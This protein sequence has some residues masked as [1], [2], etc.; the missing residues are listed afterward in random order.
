M[1]FYSQISRDETGAPKKWKMSSTLPIDEDSIKSKKGGT[2]KSSLAGSNKGTPSSSRENSNERKSRINLSLQKAGRKNSLTRDGSSSEQSSSRE[3]S[4]ENKVKGDEKKLKKTDLDKKNRSFSSDSSKVRKSLGSDSTLNSD[5][6]KKKRGRPKSLDLSSKEMA[7]GDDDHFKSPD[8]LTPCN[9]GFKRKKGR[10]KETPPVLYAEPPVETS[11]LENMT[12]YETEDSSPP[13]KRKPGRPKKVKMF[14]RDQLKSI[15]KSDNLKAFNIKRQYGS[16]IGKSSLQQGFRRAKKL[17]KLKPVMTPIQINKTD[18]SSMSAVETEG[19]EFETND[20]S[21][22]NENGISPNEKR[23]PGRPLGAKNKQIYGALTALKN[24][25]K[26]AKAIV[27]RKITQ[28][29][30][31][32]LKKAISRG[33]G[34]PPGTKNKSTPGKLSG[35][36]NTDKVETISNSSKE[37]SVVTEKDEVPDSFFENETEGDM[38]VSTVDEAIETVLFKARHDISIELKNRPKLSFRPQGFFKKLTSV[39]SVAKFKKE[40]DIIRKI[41]KKRIL[42]THATGE[43]F[44]QNVKPLASNDLRRKLQSRLIEKM[45]FEHNIKPTEGKGAMQAEDNVQKSENSL[46]ETNL[47]PSEDSKT[48]L[49]SEDSAKSVEVNG[50][51]QTATL[52]E[53]TIIKPDSENIADT[54]NVRKQNF[55]F[56]KFSDTE[57]V[58]SELSTNSIGSLKRNIEKQVLILGEENT[59]SDDQ[60]VRTRQRFEII[61]G[62][63]RKRTLSGEFDLLDEKQL[64]KERKK[65]ERIQTDDECDLNQLQRETIIPKKKPLFKRKKSPIKKSPTLKVKDGKIVKKYVSQ[66]TAYRNRMLKQSPFLSRVRKKRRK[67]YIKRNQENSEKTLAAQASVDSTNQSGKFNSESMENASFVADSP[68][69]KS[70]YYRQGLFEK[71]TDVTLENKGESVEDIQVKD[72][73]NSNNVN[74]GEDG[75]SDDTECTIELKDDILPE[76]PP[77]EESVDDSD[78]IDFHAEMKLESTGRELYTESE[79][80][81]REMLFELIDDIVEDLEKKRGSFNPS[82]DEKCIN[83]KVETSK[84]KENVGEHVGSEINE[85]NCVKEDIKDCQNEGGDMKEK[86]Q[87]VN[88]SNCEEPN[89]MI[90]SERILGTKDEKESS[91]VKQTIT[92]KNEDN[93]KLVSE[94][95]NVV[96]KEINEDINSSNVDTAIEGEAKQIKKV[97]IKHKMKR[98]RYIPL[99][100]RK[101]VDNVTDNKIR[102]KPGRKPKPKPDSNITSNNETISETVIEKKSNPVESKSPETSVIRK[103]ELRQKISRSPLDNIALKQSLEENEYLR[104]EAQKLSRKEAKFKLK[105]KIPGQDSLESSPVQNKDQESTENTVP[106]IPELTEESDTEIEERAESVEDLLKRC[107]PCKIVLKDFIKELERAQVQAES[108]CESETELQDIPNISDEEKSNSSIMQNDTENKIE[109]ASQGETQLTNAIESGLEDTDKIDKIGTEAGH[110][111]NVNLS[112]STSNENVNEACASQE[113]AVNDD[114]NNVKLDTPCEQEKI[115][116]QSNMHDVKKNEIENSSPNTKQRALRPKR[117]TPVK[118]QELSSIQVAITPPKKVRK[119]KSINEQQ[120]ARKTVPPLKIKV[121]GGF[122]SRRK[123]YIVEPSPDSPVELSSKEEQKAEKKKEKSKTKSGNKSESSDSEKHNKNH[124]HHHRKKTKTPTDDINIEQSKSMTSQ[125]KDIPVGQSAVY[126]E[127]PPLKAT[128]AYEANFLQFIQDKDKVEQNMAAFSNSLGSKSKPSNQSLLKT[129]QKDNT[130]LNLAMAKTSPTSS[131]IEPSNAQIQSDTQNNIENTEVQYVCSQC[132]NVVYKTKEQIAQHYREVHPGSQFIYKPLPEATENMATIENPGNMENNSLH[133]SAG[134]NEQPNDDDDSGSLNLKIVDVV[135]LKDQE[136]LID[137]NTVI[138][139]EEQVAPVHSVPTSQIQT[140]LRIPSY[141][142]IV[143]APPPYPVHSNVLP[144]PYSVATAGSA[145]QGHVISALQEQLQLKSKLAAPKQKSQVAGKIGNSFKCEKCNVHAPMLAAMV[146]H[147]RNSHKEIPR[148]FQC[149]YCKDMEAETEALIHQHIKKLHPTNNP[150]PPV[151]LSEPAK[152]NLKT[153]SVRLPEGIKLGEGNSIEKDI[154]MCLKCKEHMPSLET[155]YEHLEHEHSE[156]FA[157][158][159]PVCKVFKSKTEHLVN[160]HIKVVHNRKSSEVN[161]SLAIDGN[162]FVRIQCLVKDKTKSGQR[163][164]HSAQ[165]KQQPS[166]VP[167]TVQQ[168]KP[169]LHVPGLTTAHLQLQPIPQVSIPQE[170]ST[171]VSSMPLNPL[172][173]PNLNFSAPP[174]GTKPVQAPLVPKKKKSLLESIQKIKVQKMEQQGLLSQKGQSTSISSTIPSHP[175]QLI[176]SKP[177]VS[178]A[179]VPPPLMRAPPPLIRYDQLNKV[180]SPQSIM[181]GSALQ[182]QA[183]LTNLQRLQNITSSQTVLSSSGTPRSIQSSLFD[184]SDLDTLKTPQSQRPVLNVPV[185]SRPSSKGPFQKVPSASSTPDNTETT[186]TGSPLDLSKTT[187]SASPVPQGLQIPNMGPVQVSGAS[188]NPD[189]FQ[190]F[191][192]RPSTQMQL[193]RPQIPVPQMLTQPIMIPQQVRQNTP[194]TLAYRP[195]GSQ[196]IATSQVQQLIG[197]PIGTAAVIGNMVVSLGNMTQ[198][199]PAMPVGNQALQNAQFVRMSAPPIQIPQVSV[200]NSTGNAPMAIPAQSKNSAATPPMLNKATLFRCPY[201]P[202]ITPLRFDQVQS[203]IENKHPGSSILFKPYESSR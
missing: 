169:T 78:V 25:R 19:S 49:L 121:K 145:A 194:S 13:I 162:H 76:E 178:S 58:C 99:S 45:K 42:E 3:S 87:I 6:I 16:K 110:T 197:M 198:G 144:P 92:L 143:S 64:R 82:A 88:L 90:V 68:T 174:A 181:F 124:H 129:L 10:P 126:I 183:T 149:P 164:S 89:K 20:K 104:N 120:T 182:N 159:C 190:V 66:L 71:F 114:T 18:G 47:K 180:S 46:N 38:D 150:N 103:F 34:R 62:K 69:V 196:M 54:K 173:Q 14:N 165:Q 163:S 96:D 4:L 27:S 136:N 86:S 192:L 44:D 139:K 52:E 56:S 175:S 1:N 12:D 29:G 135:S 193:P 161:V 36:V 23:K 167:T 73:K 32:S 35:K 157:Y 134:D 55:D 158:V 85:K 130:Y 111:E 21:K 95:N 107:R 105:A 116:N 2:S 195:A 189:L 153:L 37:N 5:K 101:Q 146:A 115:E 22:V 98:K 176:T 188:V 30:S 26:A 100:K 147:L 31:Q 138:S 79:I 160:N 53:R 131:K 127:K 8:P 43:D 9:I 51:L 93:L 17:P 200:L 28:F 39:K 201:C 40:K 48:D 97:R 80:E 41:R 108:S 83:E 24:K 191:N 137:H 60:T 112:I 57:S 168:S 11:P 171:H 15:G 94:E 156:I 154:Y 155:I 84:I 77:V 63:K 70:D 33:P 202:S 67:P 140:Q 128:D 185:V 72:S 184:T 151:A 61:P 91:E 65:A 122:S 141:P 109:D 7:N 50:A 179:A 81:I 102:K 125:N 170:N 152:R 106:E 119:I 142:L 75:D 118:N 113:S 177:N 203:H 172:Q 59:E 148:L 117:S 133:S 74:N 187:P 123:T 166:P 132:E 199:I 186:V